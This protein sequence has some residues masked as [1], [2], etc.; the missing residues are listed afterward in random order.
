MNDNEIINLTISGRSMNLYELSTKLKVA[1]YNGFIFN[2]LNTLTINIYSHLRYLNI[3]YYLKLQIP[4]RHRQFFRVI[5]Q[6][7][8]YVEK[9]CNDVENPFQFACQKWFNRLN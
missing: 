8:K 9:F 5:S 6:N 4:M 7:R 3:S 2:Q 1:R